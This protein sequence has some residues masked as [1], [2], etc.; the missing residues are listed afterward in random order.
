MLFIVGNYLT[1]NIFAPTASKTSCSI[2]FSTFVRKT[3][4]IHIFCKIKWCFKNQ[5][6]KVI[7]QSSF[8]KSFVYNNSLNFTILMR[9][10]FIFGLCIPFASSNFEGACFL[11]TTKVS[12]IFKKLNFIKN[13]FI[14]YIQFNKKNLF[15]IKNLFL[16]KGYKKSH[17]FYLKNK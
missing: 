16:T 3:N 7:V 10:Y 17:V 6:C 14:W 1:E 4:K 8:V 9:I 12:I 11:S 13:P 2:E 15:Y 5:K